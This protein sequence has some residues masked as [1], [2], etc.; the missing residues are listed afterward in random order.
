MT[1]TQTQPT[2]EYVDVDK[3]NIVVKLENDPRLIILE[4]IR[5]EDGKRYYDGPNSV[6]L[7]VVNP[8]AAQLLTN[9]PDYGIHAVLHESTLNLGTAVLPAGIKWGDQGERD[10]SPYFHCPIN[11]TRSGD[12]FL[13]MELVGD[14]LVPTQS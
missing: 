3:K 9:S 2:I 13:P 1:V 5:E 14:K 6:Y 11:L 8:K 12:Q 10:N 7:T 4:F